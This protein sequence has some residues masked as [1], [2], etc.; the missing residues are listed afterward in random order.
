MK[1]HTPH[2]LTHHSVLPVTLPRAKV[3]P[4]ALPGRV[5]PLPRTAKNSSAAERVGIP[6]KDP[7]KGSI[8]ATGN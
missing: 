6:K 7:E 2:T 8:S 5:A 3:T 4:R 1:A